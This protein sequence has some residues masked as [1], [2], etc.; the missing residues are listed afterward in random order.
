MKSMPFLL[1]MTFMFAGS[2]EAF[3]GYNSTIECAHKACL[4]LPNDAARDLQFNEEST[5]EPMSMLLKAD[6]VPDS[7][8][9]ALFDESFAVQKDLNRL[10]ALESFFRL[11]T[12]LKNSNDFIRSQLYYL[13]GEARFSVSAVG[14]R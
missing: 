10:E 7:V 9:L 4:I 5:I 11:D 14:H 2:V 8:E 3:G 12:L 6:V 13:P 1:T